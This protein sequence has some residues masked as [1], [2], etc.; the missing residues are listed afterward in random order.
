MLPEYHRRGLGTWLTRYCNDLA[1][2]VGQPTYVIGRP[3]AWKMLEVTGFE[4]L[5]TI[6]FDTREY[7]SA[8]AAVLKIYKRSPKAA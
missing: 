4:L 7:G 8:E 1:D 5:Q 6:E 3:K 2:Q